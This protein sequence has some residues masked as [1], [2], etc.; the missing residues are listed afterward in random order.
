M[1]TFNPADLAARMRAA[2]VEGLTL[3]AERVRAITV[4]RTPLEEGDLRSSLTVIPAGD[5][6]QSAVVSD[7]PYAVTQ[8][9]DLD[10]RHDDGENKYLEKATVDAIPEVQAIMQAAVNRHMRG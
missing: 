10:L 7:A 4:P 8:H 6:L 1:T 9:E 2:A 3:A 5:D